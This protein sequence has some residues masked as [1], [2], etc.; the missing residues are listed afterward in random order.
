MKMSKK[1]YVDK[2][3]SPAIVATGTGIK[4]VEYV[5]NDKPYVDEFGNAHYM[6]ELVVV[7]ESDF[8]EVVN[9]EMD[10]LSAMFY[11]FAR[12]IF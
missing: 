4:R 8:F 3:L 5:T 10:S 11:D 6:E 12:R 7:Y 2:F 9:V 1:E